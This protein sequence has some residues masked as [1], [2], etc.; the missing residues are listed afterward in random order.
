[1]KTVYVFMYRTT[2]AGNRTSIETMA[3]VKGMRRHRYQRTGLGIV[4]LSSILVLWFWEKKEKKK[5]AF[6][7]NGKVS[8]FRNGGKDRCNLLL[9]GNE[10]QRLKH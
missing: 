7:T 2:S 5:G 9:L 6:P 8:V 10:K 4:P 1:M 3:A